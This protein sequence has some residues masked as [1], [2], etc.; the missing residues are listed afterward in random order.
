MGGELH[1]NLIQDNF[2]KK[3]KQAQCSYIMVSC[4][5]HFRID[6]QC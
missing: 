4:Y 1:H 6:H 5:V 3:N 2:L